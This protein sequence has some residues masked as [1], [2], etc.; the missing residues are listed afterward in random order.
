[1]TY[2]PILKLALGVLLAAALWYFWPERSATFAE[3][4]GG[5]WPSIHDLTDS[6]PGPDLYYFRKVW[7]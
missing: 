3:R 6:V 1:M 4:F 5:P 2:D 7:I